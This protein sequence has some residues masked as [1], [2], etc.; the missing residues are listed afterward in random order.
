MFL[1]WTGHIMR[2]SYY[3]TTSQLS[4]YIIIDVNYFTDSWVELHFQQ[5]QGMSSS[6]DPSMQRS[7]LP[8]SAMEKLL[9]EAQREF[10]RGSSCVGSAA[11]TAASSRGRSVIIIISLGLI[12]T[13]P[14]TWLLLLLFPWCLQA[15]CLCVWTWNC[16][17]F[18]CI[19]IMAVSLTPWG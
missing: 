10:S 6:Q 12:R 5:N 2:P 13:S 1:P 19:I 11:S 8:S 14:C 3:A 15:L 7:P 18:V 4:N 17:V 9:L 16:L